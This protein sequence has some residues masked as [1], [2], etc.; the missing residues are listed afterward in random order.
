MRE[1]SDKHQYEIEPRK[2]DKRSL[3]I[4]AS[5]SKDPKRGEKSALIFAYSFLM[6]HPEVTSVGL[7]HTYPGSGPV[8]RFVR[9]IKPGTVGPIVV[10]QDAEGNLSIVDGQ[11]R[12]KAQARQ[13]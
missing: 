13:N 6:E 5:A 12:V 7:Y 8:R 11:T 2:G 1:N 3:M 4:E 9:E 10:N